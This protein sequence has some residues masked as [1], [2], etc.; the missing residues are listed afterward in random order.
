MMMICVS[1]N[2][3]L[4][5]LTGFSERNSIDDPMSPPEPTPTRT[6]AEMA[7]QKSNQR[8]KN[9]LRSAAWPA[10]LMFLASCQGSEEAATNTAADTYSLSSELFYTSDAT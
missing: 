6:G 7:E 3:Q 1:W 9:K 2:T 4:L 5:T 8:S 10:A